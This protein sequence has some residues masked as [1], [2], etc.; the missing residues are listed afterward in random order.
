[1]S[2]EIPH[3][4]T[5]HSTHT[6]EKNIFL[7]YS[8]IH[9]S[10]SLS[11]LSLTMNMHRKESCLQRCRFSLNL[12][13]YTVRSEGESKSRKENHLPL[14]GFVLELRV[15]A[16][17]H[18]PSTNTT[19]EAWLSYITQNLHRQ[20]WLG[21]HLSA[22]ACRSGLLP[23]SAG[24]SRPQR[25]L[26]APGPSPPAAPHPAQLPH[27]R[28]R[29]C[30]RRA[31]MLQSSRSR[32]C[33]TLLARH[34]SC[35]RDASQPPAT[36]HPQ[37]TRG[38]RRGGGP[39]FPY[40]PPARRLPVSPPHRRNQG[41]PSP[42]MD[43]PPTPAGVGQTAT[44]PSSRRERGTAQPSSPGGGTD[45]D[46]TEHRSTGLL[47]KKKSGK[48]ASS[49]A[50]RPPRPHKGSLPIPTSAP[51]PGNGRGGPAHLRPATT[52]AAASPLSGRKAKQHP[53]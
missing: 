42:L 25:S 2:L 12:S 7:P 22:A 28:G 35:N 10:I 31:R 3:D 27:P 49:A 16:F 1:M 43:G 53:L 5:S 38:G 21:C 18:L 36:C 34:P 11:Y 6:L 23:S 41:R 46:D 50:R 33:C 13:N 14:Q 30:Q 47:T 19:E 52:P 17:C 51:A 26:P 24:T 20:V 15:I 9:F 40:R 37:T 45:G 48:A 29:R 44:A 4:K 39:P 8:V 32:G